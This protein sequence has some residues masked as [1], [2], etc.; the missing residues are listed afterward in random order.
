MPID[1]PSI[2]NEQG[3]TPKGELRKKMKRLF[4]IFL[5]VAAAVLIGS[6]GP[7]SLWADGDEALETGIDAYVYAYPLVLMDV[8][9]LYVERA[10]GAKNNMFFLG[11]VFADVESKAPDDNLLASGAWLD[12]SKEPVILH[13]P[14]FGSR[15]RR[16][17]VIDGWTHMLTV[18]RTG[19][20]ARDFALVGPNWTGEL[21]SGVIVVNSPTDMVL[22]QVHSRS[23]REIED[24]A[25]VC[26]LLELMSLKA[27][28]SDGRPI[29]APPDGAY[30]NGMAM[31]P[32][33][34]QIAEMD[35]KTFFTYFADLLSSNPPSAADAAMMAKIASLGIVPGPQFD[36]E[37]LDPVVKDVLSRSVRPA[38]M[39][40]R[41]PSLPRA[42][43][44]ARL[45]PS[46][47]AYYL[48]RA[49]SAMVDL[50]TN[51]PVHGNG[52]A[53][54]PAERSPSEE[55]IALD[56][57]ILFKP[58]GHRRNE[59][60]FDIRDDIARGQEFLKDKTAGYSQVLEEKR[61]ALFD[62][63]GRRKERLVVKRVKTPNFLLAVED[64]KE[65][66]IRQVLITSRGCVTK[67]F[68]VTRTL[69]NGVASRFEVSYPENMAIL[70]LRTTVRSATDDLKEVV[71][72]PYSPEID[73]RE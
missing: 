68:R 33:S 20:E 73:T 56:N 59:T 37:S 72:T 14:D 26:S 70:A 62:S 13:I 36:F 6:A 15:Y 16:V 29:D 57:G 10:T 28:G 49:H 65:R 7:R 21:P 22:V 5:A 42:I 9:R 54:S 35:A 41:Q 4:V 67:G 52:E 30:A 17:Q 43:S 69:D 8:T 64:L 23:S 1:A 60:A 3:S 50:A 27:L 63:K 71:Y 55:T 40:V 44:D 19:S 18:L 24:I 45:D 32:P 47:G 53:L 48:S 39:R 46:P 31:K 12:L 38:Q 66:T 51:I 34:E 2:A 61:V 25:A 58:E 11:R